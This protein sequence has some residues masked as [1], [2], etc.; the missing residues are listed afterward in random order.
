MQEGKKLRIQKLTDFLT[1]LG[2]EIK[3]YDEQ[4]G[5]RYI[6][7]ITVRENCY[8]VAFKAGIKIEIEKQ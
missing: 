4:M 8:E 2:Q 6:E 5:R 1:G 7:R 3:E